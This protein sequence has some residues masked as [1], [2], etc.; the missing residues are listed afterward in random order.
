[1]YIINLNIFKLRSTRT[2]ARGKNITCITIC[3]HV[4]TRAII[5]TR[6]SIQVLHIYLHEKINTRLFSIEVNQLLNII[7][8]VNE[9][10]LPDK[11][12]DCLDRTNNVFYQ[13][14]S[15]V[16]FQ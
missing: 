10:F 7:D 13:F 15:F 4:M 6:V 12:F 5:L 2:E 16:T 8:N 1:M 14:E 9:Y 3:P 11:H